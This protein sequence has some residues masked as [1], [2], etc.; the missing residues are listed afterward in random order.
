VWWYLLIIPALR[1]LG[2]ENHEFKFREGYVLRPCCKTTATI[3]MI[4]VYILYAY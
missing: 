2:Q 1:R 4:I 3:I